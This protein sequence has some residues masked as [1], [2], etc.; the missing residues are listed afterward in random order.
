MYVIQAYCT[1]M[2]WCDVDGCTFLDW[3][4]AHDA[5]LDLRAN[6]SKWLATDPLRQTRIV[7]RP[8]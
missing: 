6:D 1:G 4:A 8:D 7:S 5:E 2:G 3:S